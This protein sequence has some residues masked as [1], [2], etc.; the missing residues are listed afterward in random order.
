MFITSVC[1]GFF[2]ISITFG[3]LDF[4]ATRLKSMP[5]NLKN[6]KKKFE[7]CSRK[8]FF[9]GS[10]SDFFSFSHFSPRDVDF[11]DR[12]FR[13]KY[14]SGSPLLDS[15]SKLIRSASEGVEN[16]GWKWSTRLFLEI[17]YFFH[18]RMNYWWYLTSCDVKQHDNDC[19]KI[20]EKFW[21]FFFC[22]K[23]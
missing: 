20:I 19:Q 10:K 21:K 9:W 23:K 22:S 13:L 2:E 5:K 4:D 18:Q 16:R 15:F 14:T 17:F 12:F 1:S 3:D 8:F 7:K 11:L 6:I